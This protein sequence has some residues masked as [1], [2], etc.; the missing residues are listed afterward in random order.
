MK[1]GFFIS[2]EGIEG[3]GKSTQSRLLAEALRGHGRQVLETREPGGTPLGE[4]LRR[5]VKHGPGPVAVAP[6]TELLLMCASRA[7]LV[8]QVILPFLET[9]GIV[10]CDRFADSTTAYQGHGRGLDL[11]LIRRL[12]DVTTGGCWPDL[13]ILLDLEV[14]TGLGRAHRRAA[15]LPVDRFEAEAATFHQRVRD[16]FLLLARAEPRRFRVFAAASDAHFLHTA[17]LAEVI[18]ALG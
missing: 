3:A 1:T 15:E 14:R 2:F 10:L 18:H 8:R 11:D 9:G 7:Q 6:E 17:I 13:T 12:H 5:L 16:G 4:E